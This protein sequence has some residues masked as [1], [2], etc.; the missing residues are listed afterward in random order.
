MPELPEV[1]IVK[2]SLQNK[3]I[4]QKINKV[5]VFNRRLRHKLDY[6]FENFFKN[7]RIKNITRKSKFIIFH[8]I[9]DKYCILHL[10]MSGTLHLIKN[11]YSSNFTNL[12]FYQSKL[13]PEKHNH[14][15]FSFSNFKLVYNDPRRFG[16]F[17]LIKSKNDLYKFFKP[18][19]PEALDDEFNTIYLKKKL[20]NKS[21]NIKNFLLDQNF[22]SGIGN[23]Y[24][25]EI[26]FYSKINPLIE[27]KNLN[28]FHMKKIV[29]FTNEVLKKAIKKGGSTIRDFKNAQ[30]N[31]GNFQKEFMV[32]GR[33]NLKCLRKNC[34]GIVKKIIINN[35]ST[36]YCNN[37]QK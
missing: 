34:N 5:N 4:N 21:K 14:V 3:V 26:L 2:Q 12:S 31:Y 32:Y 11:K 28:I 37:C 27:G 8:F 9:K 30:G 25:S 23:I 15:E 17:K 18:F 22:V 6:R 33:N 1:E 13:L 16:Y 19:H 29:K 35:R 24:A 20:K 7:Q 36:F 10:G